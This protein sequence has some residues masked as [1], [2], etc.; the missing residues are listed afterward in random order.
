MQVN[1][2][3][4][5]AWFDPPPAAVFGSNQQIQGEREEHPE[6]DC[7]YQGC[8]DPA[9]RH[10]RTLLIAR[11]IGTGVRGHRSLNVGRGRMAQFYLGDLHVHP[12]SPLMPQTVLSVST[13][14][15]YRNV[16]GFIQ[17]KLQLPV[18][19][20][21]SGKVLCCAGAPEATRIPCGHFQALHFGPFCTADRRKDGL[22]DTSAAL[23]DERLGARVENDHPDLAFVIWW[24][25]PIGWRFQEDFVN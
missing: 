12:I 11:V 10:Q 22:S 6:R 19:V 18:I 2:K 5:R 1:H 7:H 9:S 24:T 20:D 13:Y 3:I 15:P 23:D 25:T 16:I 17:G 4:N 21:R 8:Y 14:L